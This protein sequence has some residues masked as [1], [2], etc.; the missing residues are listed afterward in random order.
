M[1]HA[2]ALVFAGPGRVETETVPLVDAGPDETVVE[3]R[4]SG[5]STGTELLAYRGEL[6]PDMEIDERIGALAGTFAYPFRFGYACVGEADGHL[7]FAYHPHQ[8]RFVVARDDLLRLGDVD[9]REATLLPLVET[10]L[11]ISLDAGPVLGEDVVVLGLGPVGV[12]TSVLLARAGAHV[13]GVD[14]RSW[15]RE[16]AAAA[17]IEST[18]PD[19]V[20]A[21]AMGVPLVVEVSGNPRALAA[22]LDLLAH[23]GTVLVASWY[24][25]KPVP[26]HL[27]GRFHRRRLTVRSTQV[28]TIPAGLTGR[29]SIE[30]RRSTCVDLLG[31]LPLSALASHVFPFAAA[32]EA[33]AALDRGDEGLVHA[34]LCYE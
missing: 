17:G 13:L 2:K 10:A 14:P 34:A 21:A 20:A 4:Y 1:T 19:D 15:R 32:T 7:V 6:D 30:R 5:I 16:T 9:A 3:T 23:E 18:H 8:D 25:T 28:S 11:Q 12:L 24:G 33:Y 26:M 27:G 31:G 22:A 29:W